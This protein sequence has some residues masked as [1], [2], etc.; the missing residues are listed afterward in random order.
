MGGADV[1]L[2]DDAC[3]A[4]HKS[5]GGSEAGAKMLPTQVQA[6]GGGAGL[7]SRK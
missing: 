2:A 3:D 7:V 1:L 5:I 6:A 4:W